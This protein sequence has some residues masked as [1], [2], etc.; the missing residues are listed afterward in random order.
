VIIE[1]Q[2]KPEADGGLDPDTLELLQR[3]VQI[4]ARLLKMNQECGIAFY[5]PHYLQHL[6]HISTAKRRGVFAGNRFGKSQ[7]NAA[8]TVAWLL[9]ERPWY[10]VP[11]DI[12]GVEHLEGKNRRMILKYTHP[13][14]EDH[15]FVKSGIPPYPTKQVIV[16]TNW[17][18]VHEIWTSREAHRPGK[19]WQFLPSA[20]VKTFT[21]NA[22]VIDEIHYKGA[23][24]KFMSVDAFKKNKLTAESSDWDRVAFD[25]PGPQNL[26]KGLARGLVD[27]DGQGDFTLTSLEELWIYEYFNIDDMPESMKEESCDRFSFR[28]TMYDNPHLSDRA[29]RR[30]ISELTEDEMQCRIFGLPL[31]LSG[32][33]YKEYSKVKHTLTAVPEGWRDYHLPN[34]KT[35]VLH[36]RIDTHPVR[37]HMVLFAAVGP[38]EVPIICH[39][40]YQACDAQT[41]CESIKSYLKLTGCFLASIKCEPAAWIKDPSNRT[42]SIAKVMHDNDLLVRPASKDLSGGILVTRTAFKRDNPPGILLSPRLKRLPWEL[43][44][45]R[46][47]PEDGEIVDADD[48]ACECLYRLVIDKPRWFDP[49]GANVSYPILDEE[50]TGSD[51]SVNS[52]G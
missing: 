38:A 14:G 35:C 40:I 1:E 51:L 3:Q 48:H 16:C 41:L 44:R 34:P 24:I 31:E 50:F 6:F 33:V 5:R 29:I 15:P 27:R 4:Q 18:K 2:Y 46:Y 25:E 37:P 12:Y 8:E 13:G 26:W 10:K 30:F 36:V 45:Y 32:L 9:G 42:V 43:A 21:N 23:V 28:G 22:G 19:I 20:G 49:D 52:L 17:E 39:E 7:A 11:F 47:D